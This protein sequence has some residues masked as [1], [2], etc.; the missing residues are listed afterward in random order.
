MLMVP[1]NNRLTK[2][3]QQM[4][5]TFSDRSRQTTSIIT[6]A[7]L[8]IRQIKL[9]A[10]EDEWIKRISDSRREEIVLLYKTALLNC[11]T[12]L[13]R[14]ITTAVLAG[15]PL[16]AYSLRGESL[17]AAV[18]FTFL[19]LFE[20]LQ[21]VIS[22]SPFQLSYL[23]QGWD[24]MQKLQGYFLAPEAPMVP[25]IDSDII[26]L[27]EAAV[28]WGQSEKETAA[29]KIDA[30]FTFPKDK[31]SVVTGDTASGKSLFLS[32]LAGEA[33]LLS[34]KFRGPA[35]RKITLGET[36]NAEK[37]QQ[38]LAI[39]TQSP[40]MD[41][42]TIR[43]NVILGLPFDKER[44]DSTIHSCALKKDLET[45][46][47][48]DG[49]VIG[50]KGISLS[51]GQKWR[52]AL[53]R[54][55]YSRAEFL[56]LDDIL[57]AVDAEVREWL[58]ENALGGDLARGRTI[59]LATYHASQ[60]VDKAGMIVNIKDGKA[61]PVLKTAV[62]SEKVKPVAQEQ[63][64]KVVEEKPA[65]EAATSQDKSTTREKKDDKDLYLMYYYAVGGSSSLILT[66]ATLA[67]AALLKYSCTWW[68]RRWTQ[69]YEQAGAEVG[70]NSS[71]A[72]YYG[73]FYVLLCILYS[74]ADSSRSL[75]AL[76]LGV[77]ASAELADKSLAGVFGSPLQWLEQ[78]PRGEILSRLTSDAQ[79]MDRGFPENIVDMLNG[80]MN[81]LVIVFTRYVSSRAF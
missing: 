35:R 80:A 79:N 53:A 36:Y 72:T 6:D 9:A 44:Y 7:L 25:A 26:C 46:H 42:T 30:N 58:V 27:E 33:Q 10:S 49:A 45:I 77:S 18:A 56:I 54:A 3:Q 81:V 51:G 43:N 76:H 19:G 28:A 37:L 32:S 73:G 55:L 8:A 5:E 17:T 47:G 12:H 65:K 39:V 71:I 2:K 14:S 63:V 69:Q 75:L 40:W 16:Y 61:L 70:Y 22:N 31:L 21:A 60:C 67:L 59:I 13:L 68:L 23:W 24:A 4:Q 64:S 1:V 74:I 29:F 48:G 50:A 78:T 52:I 20:Q 11:G 38:E 62:K 41:N 66:L 57:S 15:I 34:G